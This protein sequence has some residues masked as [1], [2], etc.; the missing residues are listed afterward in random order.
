MENKYFI[1]I[2]YSKAISL[3]DLSTSFNGLSESYKNFLSINGIYEVEPILYVKEIVKGSIEIE[4]LVKMAQSMLPFMGEI[5]TVVKF[6]ESIKALKDKLLSPEKADCKNLKKKDFEILQNIVSP[7]RKDD[8]GAINFIAIGNNNNFHASINS[9]EAQTINKSCVEYL[10]ELNTA[11]ESSLHT[12]QLFRWYQANFD[13]KKRE[14]SKGII[15]KISTKP[16]KVVFENDS[17]KEYMTS[18]KDYIDKEWQKLAYFVDVEI[19][20]IDNKPKVYK[21]RKVYEEDTFDPED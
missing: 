10:K 2:E 18:D 8:G 7:I 13:N 16:L 21:I 6:F 3:T 14:G 5:N 15:E 9:K 17:I 11:E 20:R 12:I 1:K 19:G 4:F